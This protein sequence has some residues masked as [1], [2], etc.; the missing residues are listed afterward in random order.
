VITKIVNWLR[1]LIPQ[2]SR[3]LFYRLASARSALLLSLGLATSDRA[4][5]WGQFAV[6]VVTTAFAL[7]YATTPWRVALYGLVAPIG[8]LL[9]GYGLV[10]NTVWALIAGTVGQFFGVTTAAAKVVE[11]DPQPYKILPA[12][13]PDSTV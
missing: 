2:S 9:M 7:L 3:E 4:A 12:A 11:T 5:L 13:P 8:A 6:G 10:T 1:D